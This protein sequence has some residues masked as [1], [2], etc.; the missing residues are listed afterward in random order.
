MSREE[1]EDNEFLKSQLGELSEDIF[2][3]RGGFPPTAK[4][5][6]FESGKQL[7]PDIA[8]QNSTQEEIDN[9]GIV[10]SIPQT[11]FITSTFDARPINAR[12]FSV[13]GKRTMSTTVLDVITP[14]SLEIIVPNGYV[15]ILRGFKW[16]FTDNFPF[17]SGGG[18]PNDFDFAA[19]V[20]VSGTVQPNFDDLDEL[21]VFLNDYQ[22]CYILA[23]SLQTI[24]LR[25]TPIAD[26]GSATSARPILAMYGNL[27]LRKGLPLQYEPGSR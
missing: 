27:L 15:G 16:R 25:L 26:S 5:V 14:A 6:Q 17:G 10:G 19:A 7:P 18:S 11:T 13:S 21:G 23:D 12:D 22:P 20:Y 24:E 2:T 4:G 1:S 8:Y 3:E 9:S